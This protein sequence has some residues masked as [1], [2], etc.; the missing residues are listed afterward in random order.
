VLTRSCGVC[1][2]VAAAP[3]EE[4]EEEGGNLLEEAEAELAQGNINQAAAKFAAAMEKDKDSTPLVYAGL[5]T[6]NV[7]TPVRS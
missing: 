3:A 5:G 6:L 1:D 2:T 4:V 7:R